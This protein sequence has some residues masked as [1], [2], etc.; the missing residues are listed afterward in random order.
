[1]H[2]S[3]V[4][5]GKNPERFRSHNR[6]VV[7]GQI[8]A[9]GSMGRAEI[10]RV[11][12]LSIQAVSNIIAELES[13]G[14][15]IEMG[16][17]S[18]GRG[19]PAVLYG[20]NAAGGY[21]LGF[22]VRPDAIFTA[23]LDLEGTAHFTDRVAIKDNSPESV[24]RTISSLRHRAVSAHPAA[25]TSLLGAGVV[26]PGPF[27]VTGLAGVASE[28]TGWDEIDSRAHLEA[29]LKLPVIVENDANAAALC[30]RVSGAGQ[31]LKNYAYIYF[32]A[33]LGLGLVNNGQVITGAFGNAGEIGHIKVPHD[34]RFVALEEVASRLSVQ[35]YLG[36]S[37]AKPL[38]FDSL[39]ALFAG[40]DADLLQWLGRAAD[41]LA[42][43]IHTVEN[44]FD[45]QTVILGGAMPD[46]IVDHLISS[47]DL[48]E[49]SV[50]NRPDNPLPRAQRGTCSR[51]TATLGAAALV[52]NRIFT[53]HPVA[54]P[55]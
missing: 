47:M 54:I 55:A 33:G 1:M 21:A 23:L 3:N 44:L 27:G 46:N 2:T 31:T 8:H 25:K 4:P 50:A 6:Q 20:V 52:L 51:F 37:P 40:G 43:A 15:L 29:V 11:S 19:L 10:A 48:S 34:D 9:A 53:P 32:G 28:L 13:D 26:M 30:E 39:S 36:A 22:E 5:I 17:R 12:G 49:R 16:R 35:A 7:L 14:L 38:S 45:P 42:H 18:Q 41:P 24:G